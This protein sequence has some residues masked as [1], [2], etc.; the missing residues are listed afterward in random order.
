VHSA[1]PTKPGIVITPRGAAIHMDFLFDP[2]IARAPAD[3]DTTG[4]HAID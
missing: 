3:V 2:V 4:P 1:P